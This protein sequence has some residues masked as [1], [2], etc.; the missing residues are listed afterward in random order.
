ML[1]KCTSPYGTSAPFLHFFVFSS[2]SILI[3]SHLQSN[4]ISIS[5]ESNLNFNRIK[6]QFNV[7]HNGW[8]VNNTNFIILLALLHSII[9]RKFSRL[10]WF[11]IRLNYIA[12]AQA[13]HLQLALKRCT[14]ACVADDGG[15]YTHVNALFRARH[16]GLHCAP[17]KQSGP[18]IVRMSE[19][20]CSG[21]ADARH[22][23]P[24]C[25]TCY[26]YIYIGSAFVCWWIKR[27][28]RRSYTDVFIRPIQSALCKQ[29]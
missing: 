1:S 23:F 19:S 9:Y 29:D 13:H 7:W 2:I 17:T 5:I 24:S 16:R 20:S 21:M 4:E 12:L 11:Q 25:R 10:D 26:I 27:A 22:A 28:I 3:K 14:Y 8:N 18:W 6:S 15:R